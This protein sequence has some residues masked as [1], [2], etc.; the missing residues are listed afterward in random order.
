MKV[1]PKLLALAVL[2]AL[3]SP[4]FAEVEFDVI[5]GYLR[6]GWLGTRAA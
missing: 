4:A 6:G 2:A 3:S 1:A 5:G